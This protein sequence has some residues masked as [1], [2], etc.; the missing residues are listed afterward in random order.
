VIS[1]NNLRLH[2]TEARNIFLAKGGRAIDFE[3]EEIYK[4]FGGD[5]PEDEQ[6]LQVVYAIF[7]AAARFSVRTLSDHYSYVDT[8]RL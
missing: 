8:K 3:R 4:I 1:A 2:V 7:A 5:W 6:Y